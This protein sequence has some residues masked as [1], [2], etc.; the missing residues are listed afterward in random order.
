MS[1]LG[2]ETGNLIHVV[3]ATLGLSALLASS[4]IAFT[5]VKYAGAAYLI[6]LGAGLGVSAAL[7]GQRPDG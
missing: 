5:A 3:A 2:I 7:A 6:Y 1:A 4:A